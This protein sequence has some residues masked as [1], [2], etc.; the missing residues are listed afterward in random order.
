MVPDARMLGTA[1]AAAA[2]GG[3]LPRAEALFNR[4][5]VLPRLTPLERQ[6][7]PPPLRFPCAGGGISA[8]LLLF[9]LYCTRMGGTS[10]RMN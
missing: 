4:I 10:R 2:D 5:A 6:V 9:N 8:A 3:Q 1:M 7:R